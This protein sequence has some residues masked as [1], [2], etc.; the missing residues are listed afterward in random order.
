MDR[1]AADLK[2]SIEEVPCTA[3]EFH[4]LANRGNA[5]K[6]VITD[7]KA[8]ATMGQEGVQYQIKDANKYDISDIYIL[9]HYWKPSTGTLMVRVNGLYTLGD[10]VVKSEDVK[11]EYPDTLSLYMI[12]SSIC[13]KSSQNSAFPGRPKFGVNGTRNLLMIK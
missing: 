13:V 2:D 10:Y 1:S 11:V 8:W 9:S 7:K 6:E 12:R 5:N 3:D 4:A